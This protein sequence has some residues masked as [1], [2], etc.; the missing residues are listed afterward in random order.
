MYSVKKNTSSASFSN[1]KE[2]IEALNIEWDFMPFLRSYKFFGT[3]LS[4]GD[5][6]VV[7]KAPKVYKFHGKESSFGTYKTYYLKKLSTYN[8]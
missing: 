2:K 6:Y 1:C 5:S 8:K 7:V 3:A 4:Y